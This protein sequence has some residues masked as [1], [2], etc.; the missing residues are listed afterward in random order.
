MKA[1]DEILVR[2]ILAGDKSS[3]GIL[4][5]R[6]RQSVFLHSIKTTRD[7]HDAQD[8]T[9]DV[10]VEAYLNLQKLREP[11]KFGSWLRGITRNLCQKWIHKKRMLSDLE[12][13][14]GDLQTEVINQW[15][16]EQENSE[17]WEFGTEVAQKLSD[18]QK[19][20][21]KLFY[22]DNYSCRVIAQ[23]MGAN[24]ATIR[25]RLSR[26]RQ[27]LKT[28]LLE[29]G[30][31]MNGIIAISA[32]CAFLFGTALS[33]SA[34][35]WRDDFEDGDFDKWVAINGIWQV[36]NGELTSRHA[37]INPAAQIN[38]IITEPVDCSLEADVRFT[39]ILADRAW[40]MLLFRP[41]EQ[42]WAYFAFRIN[43]DGDGIVKSEIFPMA[44]VVRGS[45]Q[46]KFPVFLNRR[47]HIK[48]TLIKD[49]LKIEV[50]GKLVQTNDWSDDNLPAKGTI[51]FAI[52]GGEA[53]I[54]NVIISG[55]EIPNDGLGSNFIKPKSKLTSTWG[56]IKGR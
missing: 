10:F 21:L 34:G 33:V 41:T 5:G 44:D 9:Q 16:K 43:R 50:D 13:P 26:T 4:V 1:S 18:E 15:L 49:F 53:Y 28:E 42:Q 17:S 55:P 25:K 30:K 7:F 56:D 52:G 32:M 2:R 51:G 47:Y 35:T 27:Q 6:Y 20:L 23:Q 46:T 3:F 22:I 8:I 14:L 29:R 31:N 39:E 37:K 40:V 36:K 24:E 38:W 48:G 54:D 45:V 19:S 12:I 11:A